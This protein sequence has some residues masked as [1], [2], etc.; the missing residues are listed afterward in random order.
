MA[1]CMQSPLS[2]FDGTGLKEHGGQVYYGRNPKM[3]PR[4]VFL[5]DSYIANDPFS[6]EAR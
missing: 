1:A 6:P 2:P 4:V 5:E 3:A